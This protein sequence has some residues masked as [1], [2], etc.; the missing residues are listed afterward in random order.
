MLDPQL[1]SIMT[2]V[3]L[4]I[5]TAATTWGVAHGLVP[6]ADQNVIANDLVTAIFAGATGLVGWWKA[7]QVAPKALID[8]VNA[9]DNGVKVVSVMAS[10]P[11]VNAPQ[12]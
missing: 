7:R 12:K 3:L 10:A 2:S 1:K 6:S 11:T 5:A 8:A 4:A 9:A